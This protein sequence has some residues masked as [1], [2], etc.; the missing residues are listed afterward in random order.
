MLKKTLIYLGLGPDEEYD[1]FDDYAP[2]DAMPAE[3]APAT[4][5]PVQQAAPRPVRA[6]ADPGG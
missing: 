3:Q 4:A 6:V 2:N 5:R 1:A